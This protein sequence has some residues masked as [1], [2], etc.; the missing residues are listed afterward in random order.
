MK[1]EKK[2]AVALFD[3]VVQYL[4]CGYYP[5]DDEVDE[6]AMISKILGFGRHHELAE[7]EWLDG[8]VEKRELPK[9]AKVARI[10]LTESEGCAILD[11]LSESV[12]K[13]I[14]GNPSLKRLR[15]YIGKKVLN[16]EN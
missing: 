10:D 7:D 1:I 5:I 4:E 3:F 16:E 2:H 6:S 13:D 15:D 8:W 11:M 9:A 12:D 14:E